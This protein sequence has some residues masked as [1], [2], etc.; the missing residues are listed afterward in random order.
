MGSLSWRSESARSSARSTKRLTPSHD[1][2]PPTAFIG[3]EQVM[4]ISSLILG[5]FFASA[6]L[7]SI[8]TKEMELS[9]FL[10]LMADIGNMNIVIHPDVQGK[11]NL[12]VKDAPWEQVL[13]LVLKNYGLRKEVEGNVTRIAPAAAFEA[14]HQQTAA[15]EEARLRALPL[16]TQI[17]FLNYAKAEEMAVVISRL[18]T[19]RGS[20]VVYRP[21]NALIIRDVVSP[22]ESGR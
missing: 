19:P 7:V 12:R 2:N 5:T 6:Q 11:V 21:R 4:T 13:D 18:L 9:D 8:D 17:Y 14:E 22:S 1:H 3:R 15:I 20:V 10:R 16:Q